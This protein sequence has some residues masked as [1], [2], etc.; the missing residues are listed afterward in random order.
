MAN[1]RSRPSHTQRLR[2]RNHD[3]ITTRIHLV[4]FQG[5]GRWATDVLAAQVVLAV[6]T[7]T[8]N[9]FRVVA[10]LNDAFQVRAHGREGFEFTL[11]GMDQD[12]WLVA[13]FED[14]SGVG[15]HLIQFRRG[16]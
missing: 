6:M 2:A 16:H 10:V 14:L 8:P 13:E 11:R 4:L 5:S 9:L 7:G 1:N 12:A 3:I 15:R